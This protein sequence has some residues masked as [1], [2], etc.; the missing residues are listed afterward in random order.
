MPDL[1]EAVLVH[2]QRG[3][4][5]LSLAEY[6]GRHSHG[7]APLANNRQGERGGGA[8]GGRIR[9]RVVGNGARLVHRKERSRL[10]CQRAGGAEGKV[11]EGIQRGCACL[12]V[13]R[14]ELYEPCVCSYLLPLTAITTIAVIVTVKLNRDGHMVRLVH[15]KNTSVST[16]NR[17]EGFPGQNQRARDTFVRRTSPVGPSLPRTRHRSGCLCRR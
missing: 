12:S 15:R 4:S 8:T 1:F 11:V 6:L 14:Y 10:W 9:T 7:D 5:P 2:R 16:R 13:L 17:G 3:L